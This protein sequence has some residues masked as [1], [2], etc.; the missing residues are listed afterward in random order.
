VKGVRV[1]RGTW[2]RGTRGRGRDPTKRKS[3]RDKKCVSLRKVVGAGRS[4]VVVHSIFFLLSHTLICS[5]K[6]T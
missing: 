2:R 1:G 5:P 6:V 4:A 3:E